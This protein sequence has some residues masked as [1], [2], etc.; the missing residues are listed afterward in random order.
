LTQYLQSF[1]AGNPSYAGG[2]YLFLRLNSTADIGVNDQRY[3]VTAANHTTVNNRPKLNLFYRAQGTT[4]TKQ[5][6]RV[7]YGTTGP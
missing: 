7:R 1:Y 5:F 2:K 4:P 6:F 3:T